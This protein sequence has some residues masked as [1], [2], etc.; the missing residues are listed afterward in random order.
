MTTTTEGSEPKEECE[1]DW[2]FSGDIQY[3][4]K[5]KQGKS[6]DWSKNYKL[7]LGDKR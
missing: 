5:C 1:H 6:I 2:R 4:V 7:T 3:C